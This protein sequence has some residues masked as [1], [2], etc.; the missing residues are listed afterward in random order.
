MYNGV[1]DEQDLIRL[2]NKEPLWELLEQD[3]FTDLIFHINGYGDLLRQMKPK[4]VEQLAAIL[5]I[6][7]PAKKH[8]IGKSWDEVFKEVWTRPATGEYY[9]KKSHGIAYAVAIVVQMNLICDQL[10]S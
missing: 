4:T 3:E 6:I 5:A 10:D 2:M 7:R 9:F 1:K 8:L